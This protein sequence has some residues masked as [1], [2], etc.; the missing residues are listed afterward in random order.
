MTIMVVVAVVVEAVV[1]K[2]T[3][4]IHHPGVAPGFLF[5]F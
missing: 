3:E 1:A 4:D 5:S 2:K